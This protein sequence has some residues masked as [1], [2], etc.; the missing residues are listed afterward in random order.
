VVAADQQSWYSGV[1]MALSDS[2]MMR[3]LASLLLDEAMG[4]NFL[5]C[6][7]ER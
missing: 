1:V 4:G 6:K 5:V 7:S 2:S 3:L